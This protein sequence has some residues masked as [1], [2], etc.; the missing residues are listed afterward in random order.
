M[1]LGLLVVLAVVAVVP[2][3]TEGRIVSKCELK[4]ELERAITLPRDLQRYKDNILAAGEVVNKLNV[5]TLLFVYGEKMNTTT[6]GPATETTTQPAPIATTNETTTTN[7]TFLM[8]R[9]KRDVQRNSKECDK[10]DRSLVEILKNVES[11]FDE[12]ELQQD[13]HRMCD[14]DED[15][16]E[17]KN[18]GHEKRWKCDESQPWSLGLYG[19]FQLSD[20]H[21]CNSGYRWSRNVCHTDCTAFTD[22]DIRDDVACVEKTRYCSAANTL[23][24]PNWSSEEFSCSTHISTFTVQRPRITRDLLGPRNTGN[25]Y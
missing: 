23:F 20:G 10:L 2:S 19:L 11:M 22:D 7:S 1:K 16:D 3:L 24:N 25:A 17:K 8:P 21:F 6:T 9:R 4:E 5:F 14:E 12:E 13:N 18:R 15:S